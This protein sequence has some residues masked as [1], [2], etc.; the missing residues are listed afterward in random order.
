MRLYLKYSSFFLI[1]SAIAVAILGGSIAYFDKIEMHLWLNSCHTPIQDFIWQYYTVVGEWVPY[2]IVALLLF[3]KAGWAS[4]LLADV[5]ISGGIGQ[6][7]KNMVQAPRPLTYFAEHAPQVQLPL[8]DGVQMNEYL[9]FPS[10][11]TT[12]FFALFMT[13][14]IILQERLSPITHHPSPI[15]HKNAST[16]NNSLQPVTCYLLPVTCYLLAIAGGYSRIYLSQHFAEDIVGGIIIGVATT[17]GLLFLVPKL[18]QTKFW[19]WN[20]QQLKHK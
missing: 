18:D 10:G 19:N 9:S 13:L 4:F 16:S 1:L 17:I 2:V 12:T 11:H 3:Y 7:I 14:A 6:I 20:L 15:T 5:A 8:V